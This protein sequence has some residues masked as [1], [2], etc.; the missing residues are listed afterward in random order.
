MQADARVNLLLDNLCDLL[1]QLEKAVRVRRNRLGEAVSGG[2]SDPAARRYSLM[3]RP[4]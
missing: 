3:D 1:L 2:G 4:S